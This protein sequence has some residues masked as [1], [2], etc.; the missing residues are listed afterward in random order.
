MNV[1]GF[2]REVLGVV[3]SES[4]SSFVGK[5]V[6]AAL[7]DLYELNSQLD[8]SIL[9][10]DV[11]ILETDEMYRVDRYTVFA[12]EYQNV[13]LWAYIDSSDSSQCF[14]L[15]NGASDAAI[16]EDRNIKDT[17]LALVAINSLS[18]KLFPYYEYSDMQ[19]DCIERILAKYPCITEV[20]K[21]PIIVYGGVVCTL[22]L[23]DSIFVSAASRNEKELQDFIASLQGIT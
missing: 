18:S 20:S 19:I 12:E 2:F 11:R 1:R 10:T 3:A 5:E 6:P 22:N 8:E 9:R 21:L 7:L 16:P 4:H 23:T 15:E 14:K 17:V 13:V